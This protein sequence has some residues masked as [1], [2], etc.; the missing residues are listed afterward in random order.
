MTRIDFYL[1]NNQQADA[2]ERTACRLAEKAYGLGHAIYIHTN[3]QQQTTQLD[4]LLW[5]FRDGSFVPHHVHGTDE[6]H[7]SPV[8]I[9][10]ETSSDKEL[11]SHH[12]LLINLNQTVPPFFSRFERVAEIVSA[13]EQQRKAARERFRFYRQRGYELQTHELAG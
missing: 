13:N 10:H 4:K 1:L 2:S 7:N 12:Q 9:G 11:A 6:S 3:S 8:I 5:T